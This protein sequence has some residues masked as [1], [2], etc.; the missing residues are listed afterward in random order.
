MSRT[1]LRSATLALFLG[2][3]GCGASSGMHA[4]IGAPD[5]GA[6]FAQ[7][8]MCEPALR[9]CPHTFT[10]TFD[11]GNLQPDVVEVRGTF[12]DWQAGVSPM[13]LA[14]G[15]WTATLNLPW[16]AN[17][18]YKFY[19]QWNDNP[20][21]PLWVTDPM[22][23]DTAADGNSALGMVE[24]GNFTC[25]P[26][27]PSLELV[28]P[29]QTT[30]SS[31]QF[32]V[33]FVPG[34]SELDPTKTAIT[35]NGASV[36]ATSV[37]YDA[38]SRT[39]SVAVT[40]GVSSP[41]K[42]S[43]LI[44]VKDMGGNSAQIYVPFWVEASPFEWQDAFM[45]EVMTDRF[46]AG[47]TSKAG[48]SGGPTDPKGEW[49]GG[50]F[51]GVTQKINDGYFDAMGVNALWISSPI[52][53][54]TVCEM[55]TGENAGHCLSGYHAYFPL[56]T[57]WV[58]GSENDPV[59]KNAGI[60]NPI[61][62]HF[63]TAD[64]LKALVT[65]A[66]AHG[67]RV[68]F[69]LVINH[70]FADS[71]PPSGQAPELAPLW[72]A[73]QTDAAWFNLPYNASL[74]DCGNE[75]LWDAPETQPWNRTNCWFDP[76]LP[77]FD[78]MSSAPNNA[79][80]AHA[81]WLAET[82][83]V[84]GFRVDATKQVANPV[85]VAIR[86]QL[87]AALSTQLPFYMVGEALGN[88]VANVMDCVGAD[89]L[90][91]S[92]DDDLHYAMVSTFLDGTQGTTSFDN[93]VLYDE[94]TWTGVYDNALMGHFFGSHDV[95]RAI[96]E[97]AHNVGDPWNSPPPAQ[98]T[99]PQ[100]FQRLALVQTFLLTYDSIPIMWMGDE[101]GQPGSNDPDNRRVMRFGA[102]LSTAE[103]NALST[104][105]KLGKAR[106]AHSAIR[107]G[108]RTRLWVDAD[109][110]Q[111]G[112]FYAYA[113][114]DNSGDIVVVAF[115]LDANNPQTR[116]M[117]VGNIDLTMPVTDVLSGAQLTPAAGMLTVSLPPLT[118]AVY[119]LSP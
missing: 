100:A 65:A 59:F 73:H 62:P 22:D 107:R 34:T 114:T 12:N 81:V 57:G 61:D 50:D 77:D 44:Q 46:L 103:Q 58:D 89:K 45:Y 99:N 18:E 94:A 29:P 92:L 52:L 67:I 21:Q 91:G 79:I 2:V 109:S 7:N 95:Q 14:N 15:S 13:T 54:P 119:V 23:P 106:A 32:Q 78:T 3:V 97:A 16:D 82:F 8:G 108:K 51:G 84:D 17:V 19:A 104:L 6:D 40:S 55:G 110:P 47:G 10:W 87:D 69:D 111:N 33:K 38:A 30:A 53:Q 90:D 101:F 71:N 35:V 63:G 64:D 68:L 118:S 56:A 96:S 85:A 93:A 27:S 4:D 105:Q 42:Y 86:A 76:Y 36:A 41:N 9:L 24:C 88:N 5:G 25:I 113:R 39:F 98:E 72:Q 75:N 49:K 60:T 116:T 117:S 43:Y 26:P 20:S 11:A 74:N 80:A 31:Y 83:D 115:N 28:A 66:H 112:A 48:P 1:P 37:P 70:V 102:D